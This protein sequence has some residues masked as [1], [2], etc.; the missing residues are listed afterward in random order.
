MKGN[1]KKNVVLVADD[2]L[3]VR[4]II[5]AA[6][7]HLADIVEVGDGND[8]LGFYEEYQPDVVFLD[9][10]MPHASGLDLI[11][12]VKALDANAY[13]IVVSADSSPENVK[14]ALSKGSK[15][16]LTKPFTKERILHLFNACPT[17]KFSDS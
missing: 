9:I 17:I 5:R 16:F 2:D 6:L 11:E 4:K 13:I 3:F 12:P 1:N 15:G 10:H 8:V 7:Q 14:T